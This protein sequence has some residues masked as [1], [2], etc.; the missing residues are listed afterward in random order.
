MSPAPGIP[1]PRGLSK[2]TPP[3]NRR[4]SA[5]SCLELG[6]LLSISC[7]YGSCPPFR[8]A[9]RRAFGRVSSLN[10]GHLVGNH[11]VVF[12]WAFHSAASAP[13]RVSSASASMI[14]RSSVVTASAPGASSSSAASR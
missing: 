7:R 5:M 1:A 14:A 11:G 2:T 4:T 6:R 10:L 8:D 9:V 3:F 12:L 13:G